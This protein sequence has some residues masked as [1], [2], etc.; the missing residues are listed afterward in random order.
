MT[1]DEK[2]R[3]SLIKSEHLRSL[4]AIHTAATASNCAH[5]VPASNCLE[6]REATTE[7]DQ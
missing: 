3:L 2:P 1:D 7:E 4:R 6:H 5:G